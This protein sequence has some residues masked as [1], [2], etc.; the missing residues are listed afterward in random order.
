MT[1][2]LVYSFKEGD[3]IYMIKYKGNNLATD[4]SKSYIIQNIDTE[5]K[6]DNGTFSR[7]ATLENG[8]LQL[9]YTYSLNTYSHVG[10]TYF[11]EKKQ[12]FIW[13]LL[14]CCCY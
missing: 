13:N 12:S 2:A 3:E 10:V 11:V 6:D 8:S 9:L 5:F 14:C 1:S 4:F 7:Y